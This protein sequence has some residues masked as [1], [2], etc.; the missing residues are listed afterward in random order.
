M[1][2]MSRPYLISTGLALSGSDSKH[3]KNKRKCMGIKRSIKNDS[4]DFPRWQ[5]VVRIFHSAMTRSD[6]RHFRGFQKESR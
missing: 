4:Y 6:P 5:R 3:P 2:R 1:G